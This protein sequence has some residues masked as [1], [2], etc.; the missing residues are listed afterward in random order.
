MKTKNII[1]LSCALTLMLGAATSLTLKGN[2]AV[3]VKAEVAEENMLAFTPGSNLATYVGYQRYEGYNMVLS[4]STFENNNSAFVLKLNTIGD[5]N[6]GLTFYVNGT[7][8]S[9]ASATPT[10]TYLYDATSYRSTISHGGYGV[11][12][13]G[14]KD[15]KYV[16]VPF[17][18]FTNA[19]TSVTLSKFTI[20]IRL[21]GVTT[22]DK[23]YLGSLNAYLRDI[24]VIENYTPQGNLDLTN[25]VSVYKPSATNFTAF[26]SGNT[27]ITADCMLANYYDGAGITFA[28]NFI[29][30][31]GAVCDPQGDTDTSLISSTW[32]SFAT[33]Y[34]SLSDYAK[35]YLKLA[36]SKY[37]LDEMKD[38]DEKYSYIFG[39]YGTSLS[40]INFT[41]RTIT[42]VSLNPFGTLKNDKNLTPI[43]IILALVLA[44]S[45]GAIAFIQYKKKH[46]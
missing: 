38:F 14:D 6:C 35:A 39:K 12:Y 41:G 22:A 44:T 9:G 19:T 46:Q 32:S 2:N 5:R 40:L 31:F 33:Q 30:T 17:S 13:Y 23:L 18:N 20:A 34:A 25:A 26:D 11:G 7:L 8:M 27:G 28:K 37:D 1:G 24:S 29:E 16:V 42:Q 10:S 21:K 3:P 43:F 15:S 45:V 4:E 36:S